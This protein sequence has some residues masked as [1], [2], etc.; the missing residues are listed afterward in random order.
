MT[1]RVSSDFGANKNSY[2]WRSRSKPKGVCIH[3]AAGTTIDMVPTFKKASTSA[4]YGIEPGHVRQF[5]EDGK[6]VWATGSNDGNLNWISI[7][8]VNSAV[9]GTWPVAEG[10]VD[11]LCEFLADKA[12]EWGITE[13]KAGVNLKGHRDFSATFCPGVLYARLPEIAARANDLIAS[14][15]K[16]KEWDE[17]ATKD[18]VKAM[19]Y[20]AA[21]AAVWDMR[22]HVADAVF[23]KPIEGK[24]AYWMLKHG[25]DAAWAANEAL[26]VKDPTGRTEMPVLEQVRYMAEKQ[27]NMQ[28]QLNH[29][30]E[31][32]ESL[33]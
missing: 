18:E 24:Q 5:V 20:E 9:G 25:T 32:L 14:K 29:I 19:C 26:S 7:E 15:N 22:G 17:M 6:S 12:K 10:T 28:L 23:E 1:Y 16:P 30:E 8:C 13:Y 3:H 31:M 33:M 27:A 4:H 11:T 2:G 21:K